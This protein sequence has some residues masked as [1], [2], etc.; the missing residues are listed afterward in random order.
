M[1]L[2]GLPGGAPPHLGAILVLAHFLDRTLAL[3]PARQSDAPAWFESAA[4]LVRREL[5]H[6]TQGAPKVR[7]TLLAPPCASSELSRGALR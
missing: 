2:Q 5:Q 4:A 7:P 6:L 3:R 1:P